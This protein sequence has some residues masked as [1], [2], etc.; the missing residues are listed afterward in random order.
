MKLEDANQMAQELMGQHGLLK[1]GWHFMFDNARRRFG[2]CR[3]QKKCISVSR[4]L[5]AIN[6]AWVVRDTILHE[7][8]HAIAGFEHGH[9]D[10]WKGVAKQIGCRPERCYSND[11]VVTMAKYH[12]HCPACNQLFRRFKLPKVLLSCG[13]CSG[14][15]FNHRYQ[16]NWIE[17]NID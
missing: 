6:E 4:H 7:I 17:V 3:F 13:K 10:V 9:D 16:L 1:K 14:M 5:A 12:A 15:Q 8:A 2:Y 11:V